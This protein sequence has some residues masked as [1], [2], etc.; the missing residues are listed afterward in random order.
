MEV[1]LNEIKNKIIRGTNS[2]ILYLALPIM[3]LI[4]IYQFSSNL[5]K[6]TFTKVTWSKSENKKTSTWFFSKKVSPIGIPGEKIPSFP[7][8]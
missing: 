4:I 3:G 8:V 2:R 5:F 6:S 1:P 7:D